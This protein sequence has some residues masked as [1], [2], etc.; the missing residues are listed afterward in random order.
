MPAESDTVNLSTLKARKDIKN[1]LIR[2]SG[3]FVEVS[4]DEAID[5]AATI[6]AESKRPLMYGW[7]CTECDAQA[8]G[9]GLAEETGAVI[10]NT[11]S[12]CHG[13]SVL[14]LQDVGYP[15]CTFG[16]VKNRADVVY[17]GDAT[18]CTPTPDIYPDT[19]L[20]E[21]SSET[22]EDQTAH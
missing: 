22:G 20:P 2:K 3:E 4:M 11:A 14:A 21:V 7:S 15:I 19:Y 8:V 13:P 18:P 12:V 16:E 17:I 10:D 1:P 5:K 9:M 6:L